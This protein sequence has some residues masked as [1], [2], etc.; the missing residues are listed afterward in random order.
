MKNPQ[1][2]IQ[3]CILDTQN[4]LL[5]FHILRL[6]WSMLLHL[7]LETFRRYILPYLSN[8]DRKGSESHVFRGKGLGK[9]PERYQK[10]YFS[11]TFSGTFPKMANLVNSVGTAPVILDPH[12]YRGVLQSS[13]LVIYQIGSIHETFNLLFENGQNFRKCDVFWTLSFR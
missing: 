2:S 7:Q 5:M 13:I 9:D 11:G 12:T 8:V 10:S 4:K 6:E 3:R 1:T